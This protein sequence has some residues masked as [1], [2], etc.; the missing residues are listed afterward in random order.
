MSKSF[1]ESNIYN[2]PLEYHLKKLETCRNSNKILEL[3][4]ILTKYRKESINIDD[5]FTRS[6]IEFLAKC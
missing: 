2:K 1:D 4:I 6:R 5:E 3:L